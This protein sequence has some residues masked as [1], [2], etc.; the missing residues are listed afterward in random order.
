MGILVKI[1]AGREMICK[2]VSIS[3]HRVR[4]SSTALSPGHQSHQ[5]SD[6]T[7]S[8]LEKPAGSL[9][10]FIVLEKQRVTSVSQDH[11][12]SRKFKGQVTIFKDRYRREVELFAS[13]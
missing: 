9:P 11:Y 4:D 5:I 6:N 3:L 1:T 8:V 7:Y 2:C 13:H 12:R 10:L